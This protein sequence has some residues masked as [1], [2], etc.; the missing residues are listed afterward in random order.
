M[1]IRAAR[2]IEATTAEGV[3]YMAFELGHRKWHI[4][5]SDGIR[6]RDIVIPAR[7]LGRLWEEIGKAKKKFDLGEGAEVRSCYE[8]GW[9]GFW[10]HRHLV[11]EGVQN[12]VVDSA[13]IEVNRRR[14]R[15]KTDRLDAAKLLA[16]RIRHESGER[17]WSVVRVP[18]EEAE[19]VRH[20]GREVERLKKEVRQ[21]RS[22][23]ESLL[24]TQ[25]VVEKVQRGFRERLERL[26]RWDGGRLPEHLQEV[27]VR[28]YERLELC[29]RHLREVVRRQR[30][31]VEAGE[32]EAMRKVAA[33]AELRGI[34]S[35]S[36]WVFAT[37]VFGWR[38]FRNR[39]ELASCVGVTPMPYQSGNYSRE[40]GISKAGNRR[41]RWLLVE[42]AWGWLR[43]Q[44]D[45]RLSR[46][47]V[48]RFA[49]GGSRMRR[50]GIV[51]MARKLLIALWHY[52]EHGAVPEGAKFKAA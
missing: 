43:H 1:S 14:R 48:E 19:D 20:L 13:S 38:Q 40:Q 15:A 16:M 2:T 41:V 35:R 24:V 46:W 18:E 22:R 28:E 36:S 8:A 52:V 29:Q 26:R 6:G 4:R 44:P 25:G 5:F 42:I 9:D 12:L 32:S 37:E 21:H 17:V 47:F 27:L 23:I 33:L 3:L 34:G 45:S 51:A 39:K 10:L 50:I 30:E 31:M 11:G 7:D 49:G